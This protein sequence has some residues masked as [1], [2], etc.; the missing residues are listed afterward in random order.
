MATRGGETIRRRTG[1]VWTL[2]GNRKA[3]VGAAIVLVFVLLGIFGPLLVKNPNAFVLL[4]RHN[5]NIWGSAVN[6]VKS[7][8]RSW[9]GPSREVTSNDFSNLSAA[10]VRYA[11]V[12]ILVSELLGSFQNF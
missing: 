7:D 11:P 12:D 4:Q 1:F 9:K 6:L 10:E 3:S 2:L 8:M 5:E